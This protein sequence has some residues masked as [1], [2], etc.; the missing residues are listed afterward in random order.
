VEPVGLIVVE[1]TD[2]P[3]SV[4][5]TGRL[6]ALEEVANKPI[7][8]HVIDALRTAGV[9]E[10]IVACPGAHEASVHACFDAVRD[11]AHVNLRYAAQPSPLDLAG[12]LRIA[13]RLVGERPCIVHLAS[14]LADEPLAPFVQRLDERPDL[15]VVV[16]EAGPSAEPL[17]P[18]TLGSLG[19]AQ[20]DPE[21][22]SLGLAGVW[23]FGPATLRHLESARWTSA[24]E[25]DLSWAAGRLRAA[26]GAVE[27]GVVQGWRCFTGDPVDLLELNRMALDCLEA[28]VPRSDRDGN[29][30]EGR[31]AVDPS[32]T[33]RSSVIIGPAVIGPGAQVIDAYIGPYTAIGAGARVEGTEVERS[34]IAAGASVLHVGGRLEGSVIGR[35]SRIYRDFALPRALRV[36]VGDRTEVAVL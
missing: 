30:F 20:L 24:R 25:L 36:R 34:I 15:M 32:A 35:E 23:L 27:V 9:N 7:A 3:E 2:A 6:T 22:A 14:G 21:R 28:A 16:H 4:M 26:G 31:I 17:S 10:I 11:P 33:V 12:C 18:N 13:A 5:R 29:R 19:L 1:D 8:H